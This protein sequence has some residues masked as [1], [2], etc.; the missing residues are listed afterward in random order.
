MR[1]DNIVLTAGGAG[2]L[3]IVAIAMVPEDMWESDVR[4]SSIA[5]SE[6][7]RP[8][9]KKGLNIQKQLQQPVPAVSPQQRGVG[10]QQGLAM[11]QIAIQTQPQATQ[12]IPQQQPRQTAAMPGMVPFSAAVTKPFQGEV[13]KVLSYGAQNNWGQ[14]HIM[15]KN[16]KGETREMSLAPGWYSE[17]LG[18]KI[19]KGMQISGS[20]FQFD[21]F[22]PDA[23]QYAKYVVVHGIKCRLRNDEGFALWSNKLM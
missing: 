16:S 23:L 14:L 17:Y 5:M 3:M 9:N 19:T 18:C 22:S 20:L 10:Q 12:E 2:L 6:V 1:P 15:L 7:V 8:A 21:K 4:N 13:T 11:Q